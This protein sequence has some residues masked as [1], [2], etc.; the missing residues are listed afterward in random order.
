MKRVKSI[1]ILS[2]A[3]VLGV[4]YAVMGLVFGIMFAVASSFLSAVA[5]DSA[6]PQLGFMFGT[7]AVVF[8]PVIYGVM[9]FVFGALAGWIYNITAGLIGGLEIELEE[10]SL[11]PAS[12]PSN[13]TGRTQAS[14]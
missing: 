6:G 9:G 14:E 5:P 1:G 11:K 8:L 13:D 4:M 2:L 10:A 7:G 3:K 12:A